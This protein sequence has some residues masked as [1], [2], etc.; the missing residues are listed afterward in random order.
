LG[1][2][3]RPLFSAASRLLSPFFVRATDNNHAP[4]F[5]VI[6]AATVTLVILLPTDETAFSPLR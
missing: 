3:S 2:T 1:T 4:A 6:I 5:Y